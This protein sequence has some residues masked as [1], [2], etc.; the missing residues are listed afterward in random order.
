MGKRL[1]TQRRGKG[2]PRFRSPSHRFRGEIR[3]PPVNL[4]KPMGGQILELIHDPGRTAPLALIMLED[5]SRIQMIAPEGIQVGQWIHLGGKAK[6]I[7]CVKPLGE[8]AEGTEIY[9]IESKPGDGGKFVRSSGASA[10][11][12][13]HDRDRKSTRLNSSH[14]P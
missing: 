10:S 4:V 14:V 13:T 12:V 11:I 3:Y 2:R 8:I 7:G 9:N 1:L 6:D 5:F